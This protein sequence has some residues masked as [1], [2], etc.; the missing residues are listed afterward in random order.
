MKKATA[1]LAAC[2][3]DL[4]GVEIRWVKDENE[5]VYD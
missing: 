2:K 3:L 5:G 4:V 1:K